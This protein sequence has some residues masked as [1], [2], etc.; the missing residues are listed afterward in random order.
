MRA[1]SSAPGCRCRN[2]QLLAA[3]AQRVTGRAPMRDDTTT[4]AM[5]G[6]CATVLVLAA[7]HLARSVFAPAAFS[8]LV[9]ALVWP[10][11][12]LLAARIPKL[13]ASA[14]VMLATLLVLVALAAAVAWA[15]SMIAEWLVQNAAR[16]Q[17]LHVTAT[18][19]LQT[20]GMSVSGFLGSRFDV[21][22][23]IRLAQEVALR[24]RSFAGF[25]LLAVILTL[26]GLSEVDELKRRLQTLD[27]A[28][29]GEALLQLGQTIA[30]KFR[31]YM[32]VRSLASVLTGVLIF[33]FTLFAGL[34]LATAW[35]IM[36]FT[37]NFIPFIGPLIAT[38][39][40]T[41]FAIVQFESWHMAA[42]IFLG[43]TLIQ[44]LIGNY[45]EP[46]L[47]GSIL[48]ISPYL[49]V[50]AVFFWALLWGLPGAF[51]GVPL[52][53]ALLTCCEAYPSTRWLARLLSGRAPHHSQS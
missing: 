18:T 49:G 25:F 15:F 47:F 23:I 7:L 26:I 36:A 8:L 33:A 19:W 3:M 41:L 52:T 46:R 6:L 24:M 53:I 44:F 35:G 1:L 40:P 22:W 10:L 17:S 5:L 30:V 34:E 37:L 2:S 31:K 11:Q 20:H 32:L 50:F 29:K 27:D 12:H 51:I 39:L 45:L 14:L 4:M 28:A 38:I 43:S 21:G 48:N 16:F 42:L 13:V 9:I